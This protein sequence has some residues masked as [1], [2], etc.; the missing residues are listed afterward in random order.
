MHVLRFP[1]RVVANQAIEIPDAPDSIK[2]DG[3]EV[4]LSLEHGWYVLKVEGFGSEDEAAAF[5][6]NVWTALMWTV[7]RASTPFEASTFVDR[8]VPITDADAFRRSTGLSGPADL[9]VDGNRPSVYPSETAVRKVTAGSVGCSLSIPYERF[10]PALHEGLQRATTVNHDQKQ[11]TALELYNAHFSEATSLARFVVLIICL[12]VLAQP[13]TKH[14]HALE[15]LAQWSQQLSELRSSSSDPDLVF[16]LD[17]LERELIFR[18]ED[19]L[20]SRIRRLAVASLSD[21]AESERESLAQRAVE[22]YDLRSTLIHTGVIEGSEL[23]KALTDA[24]NLVSR[25]LQHRFGGEDSV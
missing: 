1:F 9:L 24:R 6:Q 7:L 23:G 14:P 13:E 20:R 15:L 18:R 12:E 5:V 2:L 25:L 4:V 11:S 21:V 17:S 3:L 22:L 19:S 16:A 8:G 10:A